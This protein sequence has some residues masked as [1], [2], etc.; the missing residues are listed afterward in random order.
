LSLNFFFAQRL[1]DFALLGAQA[2][3]VREIQ[4]AIGVGGGGPAWAPEYGVTRRDLHDQR[5]IGT[6]AGSPDY[7]LSPPA[8]RPPTGIS[9]RQQLAL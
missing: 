9:G 5:V 6:L 3:P 1:L 2:V 7:D 4:V 8:A